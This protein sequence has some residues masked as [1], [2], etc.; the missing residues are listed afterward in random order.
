MPFYKKWFISKTNREQG[1]FFLAL[2][3]YLMVIF[4]NFSLFCLSIFVLEDLAFFP[5]VNIIVK[6]HDWTQNNQKILLRNW[7]QSLSIPPAQCFY[8]FYAS[9][10]FHLEWDAKTDQIHFKISYSIWHSLAH[11]SH[12]CSSLHRA[13]VIGEQGCTALLN[14]EKDCTA[15]QNVK[16]YTHMHLQSNLNNYF[17]LQVCQTSLFYHFHGLRGPVRPLLVE[18]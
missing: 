18:E 6:I 8:G 15:S 16:E 9:A 2:C 17:N 5:T 3:M 14:F 11:A 1:C 12:I 4:D 10:M 13:C 7:N